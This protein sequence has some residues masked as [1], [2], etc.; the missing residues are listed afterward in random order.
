MNF[1]IKQI[2]K[3]QK[4]TMTMTTQ[5]TN[6][7]ASPALPAPP[8]RAKQA[9]LFGSGDKYFHLTKY[10]L[11]Y[12]SNLHLQQMAARC[13][14]AKAI[15]P[16]HL[17]NFRLVFRSVADIA[18]HKG[19]VVHGAVYEI[20]EADE[21]AL[22]RYEGYPTMYRKEFISAKLRGEAITIMYY[23]MNNNR[24]SPPPSGYYD[25][26]DTGF[27]N[28]K[29]DK[30]HLLAA[31]KHSHEKFDLA[32]ATRLLA[33]SGLVLNMEADTP[34]GDDTPDSDD[35]PDDEAC[36]HSETLMDDQDDEWCLIC[37]RVLTLVEVSGGESF[38]EWAL[39]DYD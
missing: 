12:G 31:L 24:I 33:K 23:T 39:P 8:V 37:G 36:G 22:D 18:P 11:A 26:I 10:Y 1:P 27:E 21:R 17:P 32:K 4:D 38:W 6:H 7:P 9:P 14:D 5:A 13:P 15:A 3:H 34:D 20:S 25:T 28:W 29:L 2:Y 35:T 19:S 16:I 30:K